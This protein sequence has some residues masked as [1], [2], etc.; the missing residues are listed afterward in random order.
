M[1]HAT[2]AA[3]L[4]SLTISLVSSCATPHV[5]NEA[6]AG[7][8]FVLMG[9][10][11]QGLSRPDANESAFKR[12]ARYCLDHSADTR[13]DLPPRAGST[14]A[15]PTFDAC[16]HDHGWRPAV[17]GS[18]RQLIRPHETVRRWHGLSSM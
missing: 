18:T 12:E 11:D 17:E 3:T 8:A 4:T 1:I 13:T 7:T 6:T 15:F 10:S 9:T 5:E 14:I 16:M 2:T